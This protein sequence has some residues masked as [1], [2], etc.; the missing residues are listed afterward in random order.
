MD[1]LAGCGFGCSKC[2]LQCKS[3]FSHH[4]TSELH[5]QPLPPSLC[6]CCPPSSPPTSWMSWRQEAEEMYRPY[7]RIRAIWRPH[8]KHMAA[9]AG[10]TAIKACSISAFNLADRFAAVYFLAQA[11]PTC[12]ACMYSIHL[13]FCLV[14]LPGTYLI[15][16]SVITVL[17]TGNL[18]SKEVKASLFQSQRQAC[19]LKK[20]D[21]SVTQESHERVAK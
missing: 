11:W 9:G 10:L 1:S 5:P 3:W 13:G 6:T 15:V 20:Y 18:M 12:A 14:S 16:R 19:G 21:T 8:M 4:P 17:F 2:R 7:E